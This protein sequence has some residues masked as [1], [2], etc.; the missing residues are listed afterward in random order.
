M[1][2]KTKQ[3]LEDQ[4]KD[5]KREESR[6][7]DA[8]FYLGLDESV[9]EEISLAWL[10]FDM[11]LPNCVTMDERRILTIAENTRRFM[12]KNDTVYVIMDL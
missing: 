9:R 10:R 3:A 7:S 12:T 6:E 2:N 11:T 4:C 1:S 8:K 5:A